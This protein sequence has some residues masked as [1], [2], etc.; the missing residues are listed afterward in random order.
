MKKSVLFLCI[1]LLASVVFISGCVNTGSTGTAGSASPTRVPGQDPI[2]G[3]WRQTDTLGADDRMGFYA[4]GT[5]ISSML[6]GTNNSAVVTFY[7]TWS[8]RGDNSYTVEQKGKNNEPDKTAVS[9]MIFIYSPEQ[10]TLNL[11]G[12]PPWPY[13]PYDGD[14]MVT[15][16]PII[17]SS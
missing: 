11:Q 1:T 9:P 4:N 12:P 6:I 8:N 16:A 3:V 14:V 17:R 5:W 7:G 2:I 15:P 10:N 13:R